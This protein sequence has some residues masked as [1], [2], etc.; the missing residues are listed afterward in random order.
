MA[1]YKS[2]LEQV[3]SSYQQASLEKDR[4]DFLFALQNL[5]R[6]LTVLTYDSVVCQSITS[7]DSYRAKQ[8]LKSQRSGDQTPLEEDMS[9]EVELIPLLCHILDGVSNDV[10]VLLVSS[11]FRNLSACSSSMSLT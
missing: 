1:V 11:I 9:K 8:I 6:L 10:C 3:F 5:L 4:E 7:Y 2:C